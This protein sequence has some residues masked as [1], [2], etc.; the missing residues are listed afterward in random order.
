MSRPRLDSALLR[1]LPVAFTREAALT[2]GVSAALLE[3]LVKEGEV[4]RF[5]HG[6]YLNADAGLLNVDLAEIRLRSPMA[7]IC[8]TSALARHDLIDLIPARIDVA[9]PRGKRLPAVTAPVQWHKYNP[10]HFDVGRVT[11]PL[12]RGLDIAIYSAQRSLVDAFNPRLGLPREQ[13]IEALRTWLKRKGSQPTELLNIAEHWPHAR[14]GLLDVLQ[15][16]L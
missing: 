4:E 6:L 2:A 10:E 16:L 3:R 14:A 13:A 12:G 1:A 7:T 11:E 8:L 9:V 5:A 15:V